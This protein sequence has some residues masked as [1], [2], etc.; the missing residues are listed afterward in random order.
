MYAS[1]KYLGNLVVL[2]HITTHYNIFFPILGKEWSRCLLNLTALNTFEHILLILRER[3][4]TN[5]EQSK[6]HTV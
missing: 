4:E 5:T 6:F 2:G 3:K 1:S